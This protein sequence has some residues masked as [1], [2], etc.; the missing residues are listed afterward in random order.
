[1]HG[2]YNGCHAS[3]RKTTKDYKK[4]AFESVT[5]LLKISQSNLKIVIVLPGDAAL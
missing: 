2:G 4:A 3:C 1:M 5:R